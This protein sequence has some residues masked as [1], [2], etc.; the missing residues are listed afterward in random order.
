MNEDYKPKNDNT[1]QKP[2][3]TPE[4]R[5]LSGESRSEDLEIAQE[6][7][8]KIENFQLS[9]DDLSIEPA[10][11][12]PDPAGEEYRI[13]GRLPEDDAVD[14]ILQGSM[15]AE[16]EPAIKEDITSFS[17]EEQKQRMD[18][19][20]KEALKNYKKSEKKRKKEKAE[21]NGCMFRFVWLAMIVL[22]AVVLGQ[23]LITG[24]N[25]LL[26]IS[27]ADE[28]KTLVTIPENATLEQVTEILDENG[29]INEPFFFK[30]YAS[31]TK[32]TEGFLPGSYNMETNMDYEAILNYLLYN[33]G[34]KEVVS[35]QFQ[36]GLTVRECAALLEEKRVCKA[37]DFMEACNSDD[38]DED[39]EFIKAIGENENRVYKLEGYLFPDTYV[40]YV[41]ED[42]NDVVIKFLDNFNKKIYKNTTKYAGYDEEMSVAELAK[43]KGMSV[44]ELINM[45]ALVQAEAADEKD[46]Y[47]ISSIFYNRLA[48]DKWDGTNEYGDGD[49]NKLKSDATI[50]YPYSS[51][52]DV[53]K[54]ISKTF[55]SKYDTYEI[56][57]LPPG[58]ICNPG[59]VAI[60]AALN[61]KD[62]GYYYFCHKAATDS[63]PAE[64]FY[65]YT[66]SEHQQNMREAGLE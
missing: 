25:D 29:V 31:L 62:T 7:K 3:G 35:V 64:A 6:R 55:K 40:F 61:P 32:S 44:D 66:Y 53:P 11:P 48:T 20:E 34:P 8:K 18:K 50:Y 14:A 46:M 43:L 24:V 21:R 60:D 49:L 10:V 23:F 63:A 13:G 5:Y 17:G 26:A 28:N 59:S 47:Y 58:A 65:A 33:S 16:E 56:T 1:G 15:S 39:Y 36:E 30:A 45:A 51:K 41:N 27:R 2:S 42:A 54:D 19:A 9:I 22:V 52:E 37:K 38:F 4:N 57:G 12:E